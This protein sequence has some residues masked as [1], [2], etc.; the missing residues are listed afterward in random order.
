MRFNLPNLL[1]WARIL[2]IPFLL[3]VFYFPLGLEEQT[4]NLIATLLFLGA[5]MTDWFDGWLARRWNQTSA[6]GAFLDPVAD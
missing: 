4:K 2:A 6:F 3:G 5:A 1:T